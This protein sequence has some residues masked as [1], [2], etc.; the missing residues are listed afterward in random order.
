MVEDA[1]AVLDGYGIPAAHVV[2]MSLGAMVGQYA[3][4]KE[5]SRVLT[6]TAISS[7]PVGMDK[8]HLPGFA[9]AYEA[10]L[11]T[12][13]EVDWSDRAQV[14]VFMIEDARMLTGTTRPFDEAQVRA[15]LERDYDRAGGYLSGRRTTRC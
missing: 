1:Y 8:S 13:A 14:I 9:E 10:H 5:P 4:L 15:F 11:A 2:G 7:T 3:A 6:L 12:G